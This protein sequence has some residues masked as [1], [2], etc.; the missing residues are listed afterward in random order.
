MLTIEKGIYGKHYRRGCLYFTHQYKNPISKGISYFT[1]DHGLAPIT[2]H[3]GIV[4]SEGVGIGAHING[5]VQTENLNKYIN[6]PHM[7][8]Y[9]KDL[10]KYNQKYVNSMC[11]E[12]E[13]LLGKKYDKTLILGLFFSN[14]WI[15]KKFFPQSWRDKITSFFDSESKV[16]CSEFVH[17]LLFKHGFTLDPD[18]NVSPQQIAS[19]TYV[20]DFEAPQLAVH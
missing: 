3:V 14:L 11:D 10:R 13:S 20:K 16:I 2:S 5:G 7:M 1:S 12:A 8:I 9:F 19:S 17:S 15:V 6:D 4:I 18:N